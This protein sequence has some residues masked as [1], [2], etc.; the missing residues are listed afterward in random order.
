MKAV[1][2]QE[3]DQWRGATLICD[4]I[5]IGE[6][7]KE[8]KQNL[9]EGIQSE[10]NLL[11]V[12]ENITLEEAEFAVPDYVEEYFNNGQKIEPFGIFKEC[13]IKMTDTGEPYKRRLKALEVEFEEILDQCFDFSIYDGWAEIVYDLLREIRD[14]HSEV[15]VLQVKEKLGGLHFVFDKSVKELDELVHQAKTRSYETCAFTGEAGQRR[16]VGGTRFIAS[17]RVYSEAKR[18]GGWSA[19]IEQENLTNH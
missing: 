4:M 8:A 13:R 18:L 16:Q 6:T 11:K 10:I 19:F 7:L 15:K 14:N 1:F 12:T 2:W 9:Q 5:S 3:N 17:E